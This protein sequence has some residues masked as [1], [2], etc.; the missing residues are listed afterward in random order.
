MPRFGIETKADLIPALRTLGI[1]DAFDAVRAD[2]TGTSAE[3]PLYVSLVIHQANI[4]DE[5]G[6]EAA[7][8]TGIG[9][10]GGPGAGACRDVTLKLDRPFLFVLRDLETGAVLFMGRVVDPSVGR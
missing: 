8:A 7:A 3:G 10:T 1:T 4:D 9:D 6:T 2:F 5:K